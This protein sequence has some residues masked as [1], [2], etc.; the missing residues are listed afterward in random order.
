LR[1]LVWRSYT[2]T[3][4]AR[5]LVWK[6]ALD[7]LQSATW[8]CALGKVCVPLLAM[9]A[10]RFGVCMWLVLKNPGQLCSS[11]RQSSMI[12]RRTFMVLAFWLLLMLPSLHAPATAGD[13]NSASIDTSTAAITDGRI[14]SRVWC[15][16]THAT[17]GRAYGGDVWCVA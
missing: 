12:M 4:S 1:K 8:Q 17:N 16:P 15:R 14:A 10:R 3:E 13:T 6:L 9:S 5:R 2:R 7:G 11:A